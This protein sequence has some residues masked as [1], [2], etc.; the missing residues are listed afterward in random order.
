MH[1]YSK[2]YLRKCRG[3]RFVTR[4]D[5]ISNSVLTNDIFL[6]RRK[7]LALVKMVKKRPF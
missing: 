5:S 1:F 4:Y 6:V 3:S 7:V 2:Y